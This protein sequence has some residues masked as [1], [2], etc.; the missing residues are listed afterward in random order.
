MAKILY[1]TAGW[2]GLMDLLVRG[3]STPRGMPPF[4]EPLRRLVDEG[5]DIDLIVATDSEASIDPQVDWLRS[6]PIEIVKWEKHGLRG[7][8]Q[9]ARDL[10]RAVKSRLTEDHYDFV[11]GHG[12]A[13]ATANLAAQRAGVPFGQR[14]YGVTRLYWLFERSSQARFVLEA[15]VRQPLALLSF[16]LSKEFLVVTDDGSHADRIHSSVSGD[17]D[18][19]HWRTGLDVPEQP[20]S[21]EVTIELPVPDDGQFLLYVGR[22]DREK[23]TERA[24]TLLELLSKRGVEL[25]LLLVG[26]VFDKGFARELSE[27]AEAAGLTDRVHMLGAV[28][29]AD[30]LNLHRHP[31]CVATCAFYD[32]SNLGNAVMEVLANG[33]C[34]VTLDNGSLD[35]IVEDGRSAVVGDSLEELAAEVES[36][37]SDPSRRR[38]IGDGARLAARRAFD[39]WSVRIDR[40]V[41]LIRGAIE[42]NTKTT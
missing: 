9:S 34:L 31:Q 40:E 5:H 30:L 13:S 8:L 11:Y 19:Y 2:S 29:R 14:L 28:P 15:A 26:H 18:F 33:G 24:I 27:Q 38:R 20:P 37:V 41:A 4:I 3:D 42:A 35:G 23:S 10:Y 6:L 21:G 22:I 25:D 12:T 17:Y 16:F 39:P 1:V 7:R 36:L 32:L